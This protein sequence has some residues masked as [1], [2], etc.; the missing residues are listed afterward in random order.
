MTK[1]DLITGFLGSGK[2]TLIK[3]YARYLVSQGERVGIIEND[4]GAVNV[5]MLLMNELK[6]EGIGLEMVAGGCDYD[7]HRR[8]FK[9]KL[10][11]MALLGYSRVIV[12]PSGIFDVDEFFDLL[13]EDSLYDRYKIA[14]VIAVVNANLEEHLSEEADYMLASQIADAGKVV[15]SFVDES[16]EENIR[17]TK[18]HIRH[19]LEGICCRRVMQ[20]DDYFAKD[21]NLMQEQDWEIIRNA[22]YH[23]TGY[24]K[25]YTVD[26]CGFDSLFFMNPEGSLDEI[27]ASI[28]ELWKDEKAGTIMRIKGF[29]NDGGQWMEINSNSSVTSV[30]KIE[31]GQSIII[32]IGE[33]LNAE[34]V[35]SYFISEYS[36]IKTQ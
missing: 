23:E 34:A 1:I 16:S 29:V 11:T 22:G 13:Q 24:V 9:T 18:E 15:F 30:Q 33:N 36:S 12:E 7:C 10:L 17:N 21:H 8:R 3:Q 28:A 27:L 25:K 35:D 5:D 31:T 32:V 19:A 26:D 14:N 20:E 4:Y 6:N 2:T